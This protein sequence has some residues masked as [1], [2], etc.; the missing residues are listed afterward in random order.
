MSENF[1]VKTLQ[2][3]LARKADIVD[4]IEKRDF[5]DNLK[6]LNKKVASNKTKRLKRN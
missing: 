3:N 1:A 2:E 6:K 5:D 4:F